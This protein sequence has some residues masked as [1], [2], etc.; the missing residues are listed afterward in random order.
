M[1]SKKL[2]S[3]LNFKTKIKKAFLF[4]FSASKAIYWQPQKSNKRV[5][6]IKPSL[7]TKIN[8]GNRQNVCVSKIRK[9]QECD[10][11]PLLYKISFFFLPTTL[12]KCSTFVR[13]LVLMSSRNLKIECL[14]LEKMSKL[15]LKSN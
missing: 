15:K 14:F 5:F 11:P 4:L 3:K 7:K 8:W 6:K 10:K 9:K 1:Q 12:L 13:W 2:S